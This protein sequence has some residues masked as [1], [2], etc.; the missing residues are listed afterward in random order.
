MKVQDWI[1]SIRYPDHRDGART[2]RR[3]AVIGPARASTVETALHL[4]ALPEAVRA[5]IRTSTIVRDFV[6]GQ[7]D[8]D[9]TGYYTD[10]NGTASWCICIGS[11]QEVLSR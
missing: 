3:W 10:L 7:L 6:N 2:L 4:A 8:P 5:E 11:V 1:F 9:K